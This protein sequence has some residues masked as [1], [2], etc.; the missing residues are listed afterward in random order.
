MTG[1]GC[2][3]R[4]VCP[5]LEGDTDPVLLYAEVEVDTDTTMVF[6]VSERRSRGNRPLAL[7]RDQNNNEVE[8]EWISNTCHLHEIG[9]EWFFCKAAAI[10]DWLPSAERSFT[11]SLE[12][13]A[14]WRQRVERGKALLASFSKEG[15]R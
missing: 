10:Q 1:D 6:L 4:Y 2:L 3:W 5:V 15:E 14:R 9:H 12:D 7:L 11:R 13:V 8:N